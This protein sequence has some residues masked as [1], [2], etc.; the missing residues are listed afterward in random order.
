MNEDWK[1]ISLTSS[2]TTSAFPVPNCTRL[3]AHCVAC[4]P[5]GILLTGRERGSQSLCALLRFCESPSARTDGAQALSLFST[6][7]PVRTARPY[8]A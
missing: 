7:M 3:G 4:R 5:T 6:S 8:A 1:F 2:W